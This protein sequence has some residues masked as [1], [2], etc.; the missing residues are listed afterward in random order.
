MNATEVHSAS[1]DAA[2]GKVDMHLKVEIIPV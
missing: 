2:V 1:L